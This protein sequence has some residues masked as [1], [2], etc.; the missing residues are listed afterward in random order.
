MYIIIEANMNAEAISEE[1]FELA[2]EDL[3]EGEDKDGFTVWEGVGYLVM[4]V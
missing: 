4:A 3:G 2:I 1:E